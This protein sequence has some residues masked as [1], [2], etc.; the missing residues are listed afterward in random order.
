MSPF[1]RVIPPL[2]LRFHVKL[3]P[4]VILRE[5]LVA[6][7]GTWAPP[8]DEL[9]ELLEEE[10][11][12]DELLE[13][14]EEELLDEEL[15]LLEEELPPEELELL[16]PPEEEELPPEELELLELLEEELPPEE[17]ELLELKPDELKPEELKPDELK[18]EEPELELPPHRPAEKIIIMVNVMFANR[19]IAFSLIH[20]SQVKNPF[21]QKG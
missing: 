9:L 12:D 14:L 18:P 19:F 10:L 21:F 4:C 20:V 1:V 7:G 13:L 17:L 15:E 16:E 6:R 8:L 5:T 11:L 3:L 2:P